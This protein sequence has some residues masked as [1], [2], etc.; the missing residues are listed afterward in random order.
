MVKM[1]YHMIKNSI[2]KI[3]VHAVIRIRYIFRKIIYNIIH[4]L[5]IDIRK[6]HRWKILRNLHDNYLS[7]VFLQIPLQNIDEIIKSDISL[8]D[9]VMKE[10]IRSYNDELIVLNKRRKGLFDHVSGHYR[11]SEDFFTK[12]TYKNCF[13]MDVRKQK[14]T[15]NTDIKIPWETSRMQSLFSLALAYRASTDEKYAK[16]ITDIIYDFCEC[17][18]YDTG[19]NWNVSMEVGIRISNIIL[20]CELIKDSQSFD[21]KFRQFISVVI[22]EH[23]IHILRNMENEKDGKNHLIADLLGLSAATTALCR[24]AETKDIANYTQRMLHKELMRQILPDGGH[25]EGSVSYHRLVGEMLCFSIV[26]QEKLGFA[27][28]GEERKR[29]SKMGDFTTALRMDNGL[30]PQFG[31]NDSGRVFQLT[32]EN[33]RDHDSFINIVSYVTQKTI[34]FPNKKD[35]FFIFY[36]KNINVNSNLYNKHKIREFSQSKLI[37][38]NNNGVFLAF[39]GMAPDDYSKAGHSHNDILSFVLSLDDEEFVSD[40]GSGEYTADKELSFSMRSIINHSTISFDDGEQRI[41]PADHQPFIWNS[42]CRSNICV[43]DN[44]ENST[45]LNGECSYKGANGNALKHRRS[46][47]IDKRLIK[48]N[49]R[50]YGM[51]N[52]CSM[53]LPIFPG[54]K[55]DY[56]NGDVILIGK[57]NKIKIYGTYSFSTVSSLFAE[58]FKSLIPSEVIRCTSNLNN[59]ELFLNII[60]N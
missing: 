13:Y 19:V 28:T 40:P 52:T 38:Y 7:D 50:L 2:I 4:A 26:A 23:M 55:I 39:S 11:W 42:F 46:I 5:K 29:L 33:T 14:T 59:N 57:K 10:G 48:I 32:S 25:F 17:C 27:L 6:M 41:P 3:Q 22:Y 8:Y 18:P 31:D 36:D 37:T 9:L 21:K 45:V 24:L 54:I 49:D 34:V 47:T 60:Y 30:T 15:K 56:D 12:F 16:K 1:I 51:K 53:S 35:G 58:Q 44:N 20:A 43:E